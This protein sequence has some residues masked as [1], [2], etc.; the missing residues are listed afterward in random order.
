MNQQ[1]TLG[2]CTVLSPKIL[3]QQD[4]PSIG[5]SVADIQ[6]QIAAEWLE[7]I[8]SDSAMVTMESY[9]KPPALFRMVP[10]LIPTGYHLPFP[11]NGGSQMPPGPTSRIGLNAN[12]I[13]D[14]D[15]IL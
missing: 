10:S 12:I 15:K 11:P 14:I 4:S 2:P 7:E 6:W 13:E 9:R 8:G 5:L 3:P 1:S